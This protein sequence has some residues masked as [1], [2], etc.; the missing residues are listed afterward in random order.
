MVRDQ[1]GEKKA[2]GL[3]EGDQ[4]A[5]ASPKVLSESITAEGQAQPRTRF[6]TFSG[7]SDQMMVSARRG[8]T[9][10]EH[11]ARQSAA[12]EAGKA[13]GQKVAEFVIEDRGQGV[14]YTAG[15]KRAAPAP[16]RL[17]FSE[18]IS[19]IVAGAKT[20]EE[21]VELQGNFSIAYMM[22][23]MQ[24]LATAV[25]DTF[26]GTSLASKS[27]ADAGNAHEMS[28]K[29]SGADFHNDGQ[30]TASTEVEPIWVSNAMLNESDAQKT[31][32]ELDGLLLALN[33]AEQQPKS[34]Y[35]QV[36]SDWQGMG[37]VRMAG[38]KHL[39]LHEAQQ[40]WLHVFGRDDE[41]RHIGE[42]HALLFVLREMMLKKDHATGA[43]EYNALV[44]SNAV[45]GVKVSDVQGA[46]LD[47]SD[48]NN[49]DKSLTQKGM[50]EIKWQVSGVDGYIIVH[51]HPLLY[52]GNQ[53]RAWDL[54][55]KEDMEAVKT[56][57]AQGAKPAVA[58]VLGPD[59]SVL[60]WTE[61]DAVIF[62]KD[63]KPLFGKPRVV[64]KFTKDGDYIPFKTA[65]G[66]SVPDETRKVKSAQIASWTRD[67]QWCITDQNTG[68]L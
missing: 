46:P 38:L 20:E 1:G 30:R 59:G 52:V 37:V 41:Q 35:D 31:E 48:P 7:G 57:T 62:D 26:C 9:A 47:T 27:V 25:Q 44:G 43:V 50:E 32:A 33:P 11:R 13:A 4:T 19:K 18:G 55:S 63:H 60:Q 14:E 64:G 58:Y 49:D 39:N 36:R 45:E 17:S 21:A 61:K 8:E 10:E 34:G 5:S 15:G 29:T 16:I 51:S 24:E 22:R 6:S 67:N 68:G 3:R 23:K 28:A 53:T 65:N 2:E 42:A 56:L 40:K 12:V 54:L 66:Q